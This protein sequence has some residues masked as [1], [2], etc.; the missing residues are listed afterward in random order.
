MTTRR[1]ET[2]AQWVSAL[3]GM[4]RKVEQRGGYWMAQCPAHDDK[5]PSLQVKDRGDGTAAVECY[6]GCDF[7]AILRAVGFYGTNGHK[8]AENV[9]SAPPRGRERRAQE[10]P[11]P[12]RLPNGKGD[13]PYVYHD[14]DGGIAFAVVRH[15]R[16]NRPKTFSQWT[17][18]QEEGKEGAWLPVAPAS[19]RPMYGLPDVLRTEGSIGIVEGEKCCHAVR[20][21]WPGKHSTP[22][23]AGGTLMLGG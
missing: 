6:A 19:G 3:E 23:W 20:E 10:P 21:A 4:G 11:K 8:T 5:S 14:S 13:T 22:A 15:D 2:V 7:T 17:P 16:A 18:F 1:K 12:R 9:P